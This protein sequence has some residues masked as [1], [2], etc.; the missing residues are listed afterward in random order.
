MHLCS[1]IAPIIGLAKLY[2]LHREHDSYRCFPNSSS[3]IMHFRARKKL[4][5]DKSKITKLECGDSRPHIWLHIRQEDFQYMLARV[6]I[7]KPRLLLLISLMSMCMMRSKVCPSWKV[8]GVPSGKHPA[9]IK[10]RADTRDSKTAQISRV[11]TILYNLLVIVA[12]WCP[13]D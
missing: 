8:G 6:S 5:G 11:G 4:R 2:I 10:H 7:G 1:Q 9:L 3:L 12:H 13:E